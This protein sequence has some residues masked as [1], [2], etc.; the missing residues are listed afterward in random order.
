MWKAFS[1]KI[2]QIDYKTINLKLFLTTTSLNCLK[3]KFD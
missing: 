3:P 1:H 2:Q